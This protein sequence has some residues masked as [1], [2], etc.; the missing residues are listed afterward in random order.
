MA[1]KSK[2]TDANSSAVDLIHKKYGDG[3]IMKGSGVIKDVDAISTGSLALDIATGV[4][5]FP[6][7]RISEV[8]GPEAAGKTTLALEAMASAQKVNAKAVFID[9][10][11]A[12][13]LTYA[14]KLGVSVDD[15]L[16]SQPDSGE[17]ALEIAEILCASNEYGI[18]VID[19]VA[20][21]IPRAELDGE[22]GDS[23]IAG[24]ARLM[25]KS[26][27]RIKGMVNRSNTALIFI[28]QLREKT[29]IFFGKS[30]T[31][32]GGRALRFYASMRIDLRRKA[33]LKD[34][35]VNYGSVVVGKCVKN[36]VASPFRQA[37]FE[38]HW[39]TGICRNADIITL[40][41][42][43]KL[44]KKSGSWFS[45]NDVR[46]GNGKKA[47]T[48]FLDDN[49]NIKKEIEEMIM[50]LKCPWRHSDDDSS[51]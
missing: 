41:E 36:K 33:S 10:E 49:E 47:A 16:I 45:Y 30:E 12:L 14:E 13:D 44:I 15:L 27:R 42:E 5:G 24:A 26:M 43:C 39:G 1:Q 8:F 46:L 35:D 4:G 22:M 32:T 25:S 23:H 20:A 19:S 40:G 3:A 48:E 38:I 34:G 11:H 6:R 18:V 7:G 29:G 17:E 28:N 37:E 21:L 2:K 51:T 9:A 31:T 50:D